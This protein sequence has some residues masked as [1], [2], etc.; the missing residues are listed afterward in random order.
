MAAAQGTRSI[1]WDN[2]STAGPIMDMNGTVYD[3]MFNKTPLLNKLVKSGITYDGGAK[4][5]AMIENG[6]AD[7]GNYAPSDDFTFQ[8]KELVTLAQWDP[9]Y[10]WANMMITKDQI[11]E[12]KSDK[13]VLDLMKFKYDNAMKTLRKTMTTQIF[14]DGTTSNSIMGFDAAFQTVP[15]ADP[16]AGAYGGLTRVG[17]DNVKWRNQ[18]YDMT[19]LAT[20]TMLK[21]QYLW[22]LCSDDGEHPDLIVTTQAVYDKLWSLAD[23]VMRLVPAEIAAMGY[24]GMTFNGVPLIV[25]K[26]CT[27]GRLYMINTK[28][29]FLKSHSANNMATTGWVDKSGSL[30]KLN[31][32]TWKGQLVCANP[33]YNGVGFN[34]A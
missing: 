34:L 28:Y 31:I 21:L 26:N 33:R 29:T 3:A 32:I 4:I 5:T 18:V 25:D 20:A 7:T 15:T 27:P 16:T 30:K 23:A 24:T 14:G 1:T 8:D 2:I 13:A 10:L 6:E 9:A 12:C 11:D 19:S 22:G 17:A